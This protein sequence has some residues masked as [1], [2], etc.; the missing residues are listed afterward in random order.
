MAEKVY[1]KLPAHTIETCRVDGDL[2]REAAMKEVEK[3]KARPVS[4]SVSVMLLDKY[5]CTRDLF[6]ALLW[7]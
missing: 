3:S 5:G 2:I 6:E 1:G 7:K 4:K